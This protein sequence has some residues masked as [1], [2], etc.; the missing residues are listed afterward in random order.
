MVC[1][2]ADGTHAVV[3]ANNT[4]VRTA[5]RA[6]IRLDGFASVAVDDEALQ[7]ASVTTKPFEPRNQELVLNFQATDSA[8]LVEVLDQHE[9]T[10]SGFGR[11]NSFLTGDHLAMHVRWFAESAPTDGYGLEQLGESI[12]RLRFFL[13]AGAQLFSFALK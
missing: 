1:D 9:Q 8:V 12:I 7:W 2:R 3:E 13:K 11:N 4:G 10:L 5:R 6:R